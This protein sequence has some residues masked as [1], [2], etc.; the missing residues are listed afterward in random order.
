MGTWRAAAGY[1]SG[2]II[3]VAIIPVTNMLGGDQAAWI[4]FSVVLACFSTFANIPMMCLLGV[5]TAMTI[6][7]NEY[8]FGN[9]ML[10]SSQAAAGFGNKVG[11]GEK[12]D[13]KEAYKENHTYCR[14]SYRVCKCCLVCLLRVR[15]ELGAIRPITQYKNCKIARKWKRV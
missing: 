11:N 13:E 2:M 9:R 12:T 4:K 14:G 1:V 3:A 8:K 15:M 5:C 7:Y 6:D 10:A